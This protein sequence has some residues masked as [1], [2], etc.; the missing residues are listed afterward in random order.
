MGIGEYVAEFERLNN[1]AKAYDMALP[2]TFLA[3]KFLKE[4]IYIKLQRKTHGQH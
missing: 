3:C 4:Y 2:E 1:G